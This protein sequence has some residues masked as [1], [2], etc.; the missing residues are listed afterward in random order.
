MIETADG[1]DHYALAMFG[2]N[3]YGQNNRCDASGHGSGSYIA[4][5]ILSELC[6]AKLVPV[7]LHCVVYS[8]LKWCLLFS[9]VWSLF[10]YCRHQRLQ[11][12][13]AVV[14][15]AVEVRNNW[16]KKMILMKKMKRS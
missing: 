4:S 1:M 14:A 10:L 6:T 15:V 8:R 3:H 2:L 9:V 16:K 11:E 7:C 12:A 5:K 13:E